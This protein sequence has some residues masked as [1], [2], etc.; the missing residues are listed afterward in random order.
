[1]LEQIAR[2]HPV[3]SSKYDLKEYGAD[4]LKRKVNGQIIE[5]VA[6]QGINS[7][8]VPSVISLYRQGKDKRYYFEEII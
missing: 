1:M 4:Y 8:I 7:R 6:I 2:E 3:I 5:Y